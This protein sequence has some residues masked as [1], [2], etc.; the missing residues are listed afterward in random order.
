LNCK[1]FV[2]S[3]ATVAVKGHSM[4]HAERGWFERLLNRLNKNFTKLYYPN[5]IFYVVKN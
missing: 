2:V 5:E 3:F 4:K 1:W